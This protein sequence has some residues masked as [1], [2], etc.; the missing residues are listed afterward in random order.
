MS[1]ETFW[2]QERISRVVRQS[3]AHAAR[4]SGA[5]GPLQLKQSPGN[6][7]GTVSFGAGGFGGK[8]CGLNC[9][10]FLLPFLL[11]L[12]L[13]VFVLVLPF[14]PVS[15]VAIF[16]IS[17]VLVVPLVACANDKLAP[18]NRAN[19]NVA[20]FFMLPPLKGSSVLIIL[21]RSGRDSFLSSPIGYLW[22]TFWK[23]EIVPDGD[24]LRDLDQDRK[25][26]RLN[27]SHT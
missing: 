10:P 17:V 2:Q 26:T 3:L 11:P 22:R 6:Y 20:S 18:S 16:P 19:T 24:V 9:L 4:K 1:A 21:T 7:L 14:L 15:V 25:S 12:W 23:R 13:W 5:Q 27:S 8:D